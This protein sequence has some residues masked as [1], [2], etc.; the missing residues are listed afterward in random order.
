M[1]RLDR[2]NVAF[3]AYIKYA[4]EEN[5]AVY[6]KLQAVTRLNNVN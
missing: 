2:R 4:N 3:I 6:G 5:S 1:R